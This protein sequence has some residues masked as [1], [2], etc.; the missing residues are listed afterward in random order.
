MELSKNNKKEIQAVIVKSVLKT[1]YDAGFTDKEI[2]NFSG[3]MMVSFM[4]ILGYTS[5]DK[6][7]AITKLR[8][9]AM[10]NTKE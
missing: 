8:K 3:I 9:Y 1:L 7:Q 10:N 2:V 4:D 6:S 5:Q